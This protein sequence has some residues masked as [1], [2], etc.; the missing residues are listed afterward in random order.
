MSDAGNTSKQPTGRGE[1]AGGPGHSTMLLQVIARERPRLPRAELRI[2][3]FVLQHPE[4]VITM[5]MAD[6][7]AVAG[8]SDPTIIR[9][10]RRFHCS[11]Y[12][13]LKVRL[14]Q[15]LAPEAPFSHEEILPTDSVDAAVHKTLRN[16]INFLRR[17]EQDCDPAAI[18]R[19]ADILLLA[20]E[21]FLFGLGISQTIAYDAEHKFLRI[22]LHC[23]LIEGQQRQA[24]LATT[25][26]KE[27]V[28]VLL[29]HSG[30]TRALVES[31]AAARDRGAHTIAI[32]A[33]H[34]HLA[35]TCEL[36]IGVPRYEHSEVYTPLTARLNHFIVTNML[37]A[38]VG[39]KQG[40][41]RPDNLAALDPWLTEK[42][43]DDGGTDPAPPPGGSRP[44]AAADPLRPGTRRP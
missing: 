28:V 21:V 16:S 26:R 9:F 20:H 37:V 15:S 44:P 19:A 31:A 33:P 41:P 25:V 32:T 3:D 5:N 27:D 4:S 36:V 35:R 34:S 17:F 11:G 7:K 10:A 29:S 42:L 22:G 13:E 40:Q 6:L 43:I 12:P 8:V 38:V 18:G 1:V 2:A 24:L 39:V 23:R 30:E 14:A